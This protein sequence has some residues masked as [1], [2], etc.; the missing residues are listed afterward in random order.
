MDQVP[1]VMANADIGIVP[2]RNDFFGGMAFSTKILEFMSMGI[3]VIVSKTMIDTYYFDDSLVTFFNPDS[4]GDLAN[5]MET[6]VNQFD[7][8]VAF[9][10]DV[11]IVIVT[12]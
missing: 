6:L 11:N 8:S 1:K 3:P 12:N 2:K 7:Y 10:S 5:A 4:V 9:V